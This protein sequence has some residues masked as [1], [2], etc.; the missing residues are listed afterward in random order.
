[1]KTPEQERKAFLIKELQEY[2]GKKQMTKEEKKSLKEWVLNGNSV[3][4]NGSMVTYENGQPVDFLD[5]YREE[6]EIR[7]KLDSLSGEERERYLCEVCGEAYVPDLLDDNQELSMKLKAYV[8]ILKKYGH[9]EEANK[10]YSEWSK[11]Y[12]FPEVPDKDLPFH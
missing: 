12:D 5:V 6:E 9:L 2:M 3:H 4:E 11:P 1:M 8:R 10:L 7:C